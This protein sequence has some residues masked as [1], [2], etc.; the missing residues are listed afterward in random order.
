MSQVCIIDLEV[1]LDD[2]N[3]VRLKPDDYMYRGTRRGTYE[4]YYSIYGVWVGQKVYNPFEELP[5]PPFIICSNKRELYNKIDSI[6][7]GEELK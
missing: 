3:I 6:L 2:G 7:K 4:I 5:G 1:D